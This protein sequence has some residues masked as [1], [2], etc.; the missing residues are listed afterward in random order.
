[1][2]T[3]QEVSFLQTREIVKNIGDHQMRNKTILMIQV[4]WWI[5]WRSDFPL[6]LYF[7]YSAV[8]VCIQNINF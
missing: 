5:E 3:K 8:H 2:Q 1:M 6:T 4:Y 7:S